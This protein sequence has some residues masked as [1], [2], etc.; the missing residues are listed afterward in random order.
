MTNARSKWEPLREHLA[1]VA[2]EGQQAITLDFS[3]IDQMVDGLP[4]PA[5]TKKQWWSNGA[6]PQAKAWQQAGWR[7]A[8]VGFYQRRVA[9]VR[10]E[11]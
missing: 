7:V 9:F 8:A 1:K 10:Q 6:Q 11:R 2:A 5:F 4:A 3:D